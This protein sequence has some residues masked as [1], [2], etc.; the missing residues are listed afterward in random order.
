MPEY[1]MHPGQT[2]LEILV[3]SGLAKSKS[4]GRRL[5]QQNAVR[6]NGAT[7]PD[8]DQ[9][10]PSAGVLQVGNNKSLR[11]N[12]KK[13]QVAPKEIHGLVCARA[14]PDQVQR[15]REWFQE[16]EERLDLDGEYAEIGH[17]LITNYPRVE[18]EWERILFGYE[19]M[20]ENACDPTLSYLDFKP[21]IKSAMTGRSRVEQLLSIFRRLV[22][23]YRRNTLNFQYE[24]MGD[25]IHEIEVLI[26]DI[27]PIP[28][29]EIDRD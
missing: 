16:L 22:S 12:K 29:S 25:Y 19:T 20:V 11:V 9:S 18:S 5:I 23:Y 10:F 15:V 21:E 17:W 6:L 28:V 13:E 1:T 4:E 27:D 24:K 3:S 8:A 7:L 2:V 26:P 14:H